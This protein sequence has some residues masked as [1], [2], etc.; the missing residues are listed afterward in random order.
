MTGGLKLKGL[1][2]QNVMLLPKVDNMA[3]LL[4]EV[5]VPTTSSQKYF[6]H[7]ATNRHRRY[8]SCH[9]ADENRSNICYTLCPFVLCI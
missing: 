6:F 3:V 8:E 7:N 1:S 9:R 4:P 5:K 2:V